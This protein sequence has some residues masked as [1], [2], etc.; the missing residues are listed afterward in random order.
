V[1]ILHVKLVQTAFAVKLRPVG[2]L[3]EQLFDALLHRLMW[4]HRESAALDGLPILAN[5][6]LCE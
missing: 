5:E 1:R 4:M 6:H 2:N 3:G